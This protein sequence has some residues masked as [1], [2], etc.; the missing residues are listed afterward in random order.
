M[1]LGN[2]ITVYNRIGSA[3]PFFHAT[4]SGKIYLAYMDPI[5]RK[6]AFEMIGLPSLTRFTN[7]NKKRLDLELKRIKERGYATEKQEVREGIYRIAAPAFNTE[8][9]IACCLSIAGLYSETIEG[10]EK[11]LAGMVM[12]ASQRISRNLG[13]GL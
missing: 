3:L 1:A 8:S 11:Y 13:I 9:K 4:A 2:W 5:K 7:T 10:R 6:K 12:E